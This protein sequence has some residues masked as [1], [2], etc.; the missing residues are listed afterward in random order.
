V[1]DAAD[2]HEPPRTVLVVE[3]ADDRSLA[4][5]QRAVEFE[6]GE[7]G[8]LT[9]PIMKKICSDGIHETVLGL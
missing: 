4:G 3:G 7:D 2:K 1:E 9:M 8:A 6:V 5:C